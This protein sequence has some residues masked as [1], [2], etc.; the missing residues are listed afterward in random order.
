MSREA[1]YTT[2]A[3]M[4]L[5]MCHYSCIVFFFRPSELLAISETCSFFLFMHMGLL[6]PL[7]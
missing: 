1:F 4:K 2:E 6:I 7:Y 5:N 3:V